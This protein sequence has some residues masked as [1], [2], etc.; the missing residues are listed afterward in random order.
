MH[1]TKKIFAILFFLWL[2][3]LLVLTYYPNF[4]ELKVRIRHEWF[5]LDYL[6][7][8]G[9]YMVLV[10]LFIFWQNGYRQKVPGKLLLLTIT[11]GLLLAALTELTQLVIPG[12]SMNPFDLIYNCLGIAAGAGVVILS[13][14]TRRRGENMTT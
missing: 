13:S 8:F 1:Q 10:A 11:G 14:G 9:F 7:H 2:S 6:G 5:R 3:A 12:R 4:P